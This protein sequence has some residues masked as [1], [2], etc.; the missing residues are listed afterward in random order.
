MIIPVPPED[1]RVLVNQGL[2]PEDMGFR[3]TAAA[4]VDED[5]PMNNGSVEVPAPTFL[6][7]DD[8]PLSPISIGTSVNAQAVAGGMVVAA[9]TQPVAIQG[10]A[11]TSVEL[12][13]PLSKPGQKRKAEP[14]PSSSSSS[15]SGSL[16]ANASA[17]AVTTG[18]HNEPSTSHGDGN[19]SGT[20]QVPSTSDSKRDNISTDSCIKYKKIRRV[21]TKAKFAPTTN[22]TKTRNK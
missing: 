13:A 18:H 16:Y 12:V 14:E 21:Q 17:F 4:V 15:S 7:F 9:A 22:S 10:G 1:I 5:D 20:D 6:L 2:R 3:T 19:T 11:A 8:Q